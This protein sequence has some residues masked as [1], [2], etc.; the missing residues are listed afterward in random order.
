MKIYTKTGDQGMSGLYG[1]Q[2]L[3][4]ADIRL[5]AYGTVD[6]LNAVIGYVHAQLTVDTTADSSIVT[7]LVT[8]Q[9]SLLDIGSHLATP[10]AAEHAPTNLPPLSSKSITTLEQSID[11]LAAALPELR[12]FILPGGT[13]TA[14]SIQLARTIC[15]R[16]ERRVV[17]L[18]ATTYVDPLIISYL[19]RLSDWLFMVARQVNQAHG[20]T[21]QLWK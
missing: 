14:A 19:N 2:R 4:K 16:A 6:E 20:V 5:E 1:G 18:A 8:I 7:Q 11:Q 13:V 10:Y 17:S 3:S 21:E 12:N 15:R 9:R